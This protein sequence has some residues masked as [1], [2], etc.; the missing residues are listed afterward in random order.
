MEIISLKASLLIMGISGIAAQMILLRELL[1]SFMG[2]ELTLGIILANWLILEATGS[3]LIG[4][5]VEKVEKKVEV[6]VFLQIFFSVALPFSIYLCR[7]FKNILLITPG[8]GLGLI[9]ILYS[10]FLILLPVS[11]SHGAL[12]TYGCKLYSQYSR[13]DATSIGKVY[14]FETMGS[15]LGGLLMTFYLIQYF[16]SF[17]IA[18]VISVINALASVFLLWPGKRPLLQIQHLSWFL[19][20]L[21][22]LLFLILLLTPLSN[23][24]HHSSL[25]AQWKGL[26]VLHNENSIYGNITVTQR[27]EQ[28]TFYT[29]G[30]PSV[31]TPVPDIAFL[32][33][34]V[35][36][37][38]LFHENPKSILILSN[39]AGGMIHEILKYPVT[40]VDY[41]ELDPLLLKLIH[42]FSTPLTQSELS[43]QR[44]RIHPTDGR[45]FVNQTQ[46]RFDLI[47]I[48][49][50]SPQELQTNRLF[51]SEFFFMA[52][53]KMNPG[54]TIVLT[55]P[56]SL[57]YISPELRDLNG[58][59]LDTLKSVYRFVRVIPGDA[60][61]YLA[62]D[63]EKLNKVTAQDLMKRLEERK[64]P[65]HLFTRSYIEHRLHEQWLNWYLKSMEGK[66]V[67]INSDFHPLAV[68]FNLSSWNALFSPY[69]SKVFKSF[70]KLSLEL[71]LFIIVLLTV[72][73]SILFLKKPRL[74]AYSLP[75]A[76][77]TSG[78]A[79]M[80]LDLA[81][82]FTFQALYGYLYHQI[83]LLITVFMAGI[84]LG[85]LFI[86]RR[87][88]RIETGNALFLWTELSIILFSLLLPYVLTLPSHH[89]EKTSVYILLYATFLLMSFLC[90]ILVGIQFP[91]A[92]KNYL[93][94]HSGKERVGRTAGLLYGADLFG[95]F[96]GGL[97]GGVLLLP[98]L[99]LQ[100]SCFLT[101]I[102][103]GSSFLLFLLFLKIRPS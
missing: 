36:F 81:I 42:R 53:R 4:K 68:F 43:D 77:F 11:L 70:E 44:V 51:S 20:L 95:G 62:S 52:R 47:F 41:V 19:T 35:H 93:R 14:V 79:D 45:F 46:D 64:I 87:L 73:L 102:I 90:G 101:A 32:E 92:T 67:H 38:M 26:R 10:S 6:Y 25:Q 61:L 58:C 2:N 71:T 24:I 23:K 21:Y 37:P 94:S 30:L 88:D 50:S 9:P 33:D 75:Y 40:R 49:L 56:G 100:E 74:S 28:F 57:T 31:T 18:F 66:E 13:E 22:A 99:G 91:L 86:T 29:D 27:G 65:T 17:E 8:E 97:I 89:L 83:G 98:V 15:I 48:G 82:I 55:L 12:F 34:L 39:G 96:F 85:G 84:A 7:T 78:F 59:I 72:S 54:G 60:N 5:T 103:K 80:M 3:F 16:N 63:S 76:I 1:I 69:L